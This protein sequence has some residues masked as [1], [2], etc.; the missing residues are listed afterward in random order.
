M[1]T[2]VETFDVY[3]WSRELECGRCDTRYAVRFEDVKRERFKKPSTYWFDGS[4]DRSVVEHLFVECPTCGDIV[5]VD[6]VHPALKLAVP[7]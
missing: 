3:A 6:D 7:R 1:T 2:V 5:F 4:G